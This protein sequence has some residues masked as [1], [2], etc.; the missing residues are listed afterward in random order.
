[1]GSQ[2][3]SRRKYELTR[4]RL[5]SGVEK[6]GSATASSGKMLT[7]RILCWFVALILI[8]VAATIAA[9]PLESFPSQGTFRYTISVGP[10]WRNRPDEKAVVLWYTASYEIAEEPLAEINTKLLRVGSEGRFINWLWIDCTYEN[11]SKNKNIFSS[12]FHGLELPYLDVSP[13][14]YVNLT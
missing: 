9:I 1:M 12:T 4:V 3:G 7:A 2:Q 14:C 13:Y 11:A 6:P 5:V 10:V 8:I